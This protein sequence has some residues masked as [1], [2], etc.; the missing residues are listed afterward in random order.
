MSEPAPASLFLAGAGVLLSLELCE[1][2]DVGPSVPSLLPSRENS[3]G[4]LC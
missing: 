4:R 2:D 3:A 1:S